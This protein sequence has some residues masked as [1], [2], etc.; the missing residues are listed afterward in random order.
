M[1]QQ[2]ETFNAANDLGL[3]TDRVLAVGGLSWSDPENDGQGWRHGLDFG[4][5]Q[6]SPVETLLAEG[7]VTFTA[8]Q[9]GRLVTSLA[10]CST[11]HLAERSALDLSF[12]TD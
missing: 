9:R 2:V 7:P 3:P 11:S 8:H 1:L 6:F 5:M 4:L 10:Y 12:L